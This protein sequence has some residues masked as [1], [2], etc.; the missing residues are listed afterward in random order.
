MI[1]KIIFNLKN[2]GGGSQALGVIV[3][4]EVVMQVFGQRALK[5]RAGAILIKMQWT[6]GQS[7]DDL[8]E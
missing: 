3:A 4:P 6:L 7:V 2:G 5:R 8:F 1:F